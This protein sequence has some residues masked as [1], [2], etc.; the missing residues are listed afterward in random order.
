MALILSPEPMPVEVISELAEDPALAVLEETAEL[1]M[2]G[3]WCAYWDVSA[4]V[5]ST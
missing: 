3:L 1:M 5:P 2:A 4:V